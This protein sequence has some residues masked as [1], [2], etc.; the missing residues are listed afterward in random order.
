MSNRCYNKENLVRGLRE[1]CCSGEKD[2]VNPLWSKII[3]KK[4]KTQT[5]L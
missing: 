4:R 5:K 2:R 1:S 3:L